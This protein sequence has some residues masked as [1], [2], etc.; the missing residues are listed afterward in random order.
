MLQAEQHLV[1]SGDQITTLAHAGQDVTSEQ[2]IV[3]AGMR[4]FRM[5]Y[6]H[7]ASLAGETI[8]DNGGLYWMYAPET[9]ILQVGPSKIERM[10]NRVPLVMAQV[11][12]GALT[13]RWLGQD[14]VA[15]HSCGVIEV[16]SQDL[17]L[18]PRRRFWIDPTNGAQLRIEQ[19][20]SSGQLLS[21][22]Y[23][24]SVTYS[25]AIAPGTFQPPRAPKN[26]RVVGQ[27]SASQS[28]TLL[29]A[30]TQAGFTVLSPTFLPA[31]FHF[32]TASVSDFRQRKLVAL[33]F[34][35]GLNVLS[36]YETTQGPNDR[37]QPGRI[38]RPRPGVFTMARN[39]L[40]LIL[41]GSLGQEDMQKIITSVP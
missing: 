10:H 29:Q 16:A 38:R 11:K 41:V 27:E 33:R 2:A 3:R 1:L 18:A 24:T 4:A 30:Q 14:M 22:S 39:G 13:V 23:F 35:N 12:S 32:Q 26:A 17:T 7:P 20:A 40:R 25:P 6:E 37:G 34:V 28:I 5:E 21:S 36:L 31:G 19:Y 9:N 15:G 8:V